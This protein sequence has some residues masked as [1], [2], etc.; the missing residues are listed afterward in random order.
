[1]TPEKL[2]YFRKKYSLSQAQISEF[3]HTPMRTYQDWEYGEVRIPG[4]VDVAIKAIEVVL[5][6]QGRAAKITADTQEAL[7]IWVSSST[8]HTGHQ[9]DDERFY[10]YVTSLDHNRSIDESMI[11]QNMTDRI[12][13]FHPHFDSSEKQRLIEKYSNKAFTI[14]WYLRHRKNHVY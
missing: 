14:L 12:N 1:M 7:D 5:L 4:I 3:L 6:D 11:R 10:D 2:K 8:R 9:L 13:H